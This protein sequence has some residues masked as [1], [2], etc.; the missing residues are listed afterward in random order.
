VSQGCVL[1]SGA[2]GLVGRRLVPRLA[3]GFARVRVLSRSAAGAGAFAGLSA[4]EPHAWDGVDPGP[5]AVVGLDAVVHLAGE[6]LF[7]G[8]PTKARL[9]RVRES[10]IASTRR[11]VERLAALP[12]G[13]RPRVLVSAS[14]VGIY[15]DRGEE[16]LDE[17]SAPGTGFLAELCR[18]WEAEASRAESLGVRVVRLRIGVVLA[19]EG[20]ALALM[21]IP[22]SLGLGGRLGHGAQH[23]PWI[24]ADDLV[25]S[26]RFALA[27]DEL[28]GAV[29]AVAPAPVRNVEL[30]RTLAR[31]LGRKAFVPVPAFAL[32]AA[33]GPLAVELLGGRQ[34]VPK[35]LL[36]AGFRFRHADLE[37]A[38]RSELRRQG[39]DGRV[40]DGAP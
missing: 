24:H 26:I 14:A 33:M 9:A 18:D 5:A 16:R 30:T 27:R 22:F 10:R 17:A 3:E 19:R 34:V 31:V 39:P 36:E 15:G 29:N 25:E 6:P 13:G 40:S 7:G 35:R 21:R 2:T 1:V 32:R 4:V 8:L 12:A 20:G 23:F 28:A 38:L 11:I 37:T